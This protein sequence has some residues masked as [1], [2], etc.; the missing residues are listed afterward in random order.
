MRRARDRLAAGGGARRD[1]T[2]SRFDHYNAWKYLD[3]RDDC[4]FSDPVSEKRNPVG[5]PI[6]PPDPTWTGAGSPPARWPPEQRYR[7]R[8]CKVR[9]RTPLRRSRLPSLA[10]SLSSRSSCSRCSGTARSSRR[11][12]PGYHMEK[13]PFPSL[14]PRRARSATSSARE[15][16]SRRRRRGG[17]SPATSPGAASTSDARRT[18]S[19]SARARARGRSSCDSWSSSLASPRAP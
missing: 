6:S 9:R 11:S 15:T 18:D 12:P 13:S 16:A 1:E 17:G 8:L 19:D 10:S 4:A 5:I 3:S 7:E 14:T 2:P